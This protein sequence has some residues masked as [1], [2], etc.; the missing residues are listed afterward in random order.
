MGAAEE[1]TMRLLC[2]HGGRLVPC[3]PGGGLRYVG[4]ETRALAVPRGAPFR[5]LTARLAE[6]AGARGDA[7]TATLTSPADTPRSIHH[8]SNRSDGGGEGGGGDD[9]A[10][11]QPRWPPRSVR[12]RRR[13]PVRRRR[14]A[15]P[16]RAARCPFRELTARLAEKAGAAAV[17]AV[18][19][20]LAD[21]GPDEDLLVSVTSDE[22]LAHMRDE[23]DRLR[24][25]RPSASFRV[26]V[27]TAVDAA[28]G[29]Q[30]RRRPHPPVAAPPMMMRRARSEMG[31]AAG[32]PAAPPPM[33]R[34]RSAQ[35]LAA[36][37]SHSHQ[38]FYDRRRQSCCCCCCCHR[39]RDLPPPAWP[40]RPLP[41]MSKNVN[42]AQPAGG[43]EAAKAAMVAMEMDS[44]RACWELE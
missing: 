4:G 8:R 35:E 43:Q 42:G 41:S 23:Y 39:R 7:V 22:E 16:R 12:P 32:L 10:A 29:V 40:V 20:R 9:E 19:Y 33:R 34:A 6:K 37:G 28:A 17:T 44:R 15:R 2:S 21:E 31:L 26:F 18:R 1:T 30:Q 36:G 11:L 27:S 3:G 14:D 13:P 5:E 25:T 38:C 24:A